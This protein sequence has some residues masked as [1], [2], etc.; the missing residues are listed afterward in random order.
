MSTYHHLEM[1]HFLGISRTRTTISGLNEQAAGVV[2]TEHNVLQRFLNRN[3][4]FHKG[5][6]SARSMKV[7]IWGL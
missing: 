6:A 4:R 2:Q 3:L 1:L 5:S 7:V